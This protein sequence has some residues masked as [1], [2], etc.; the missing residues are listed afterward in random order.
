MKLIQAT[1]ADSDRL[2]EFFARML[3]PGTIDFSIQ[4]QGSF[5]DQYRLQS[6]DF[7]TWM[8]EDGDGR[9]C[10]LASLVFRTGFIRGEKQT[11]CHATDLRIARSRQAVMQWAQHFLPVLERACTDRNCRQVF[12]VVEQSDSQAYNALIRPTSHARRKLPR[13]FL[14]HRFHV[15]TLHGRVPLAP[16]PLTSIRLKPLEMSDVEPLCAYLR[17]QA[18]ARALA[19][20]YEPNDFLEDFK[21]WPGYRWEDFRIARDNK[22]NIVGCAG[23]WNGSQVQNFVPQ[24]YKGFAHTLHQSLN[25]ISWVGLARPTAQPERPMPM[26]FLTHLNCDNAEVFYRLADEAFS[27]LGP[28]EF[29]AYGHFKGHWKTLP[30]RAFIAAAMR[31]GLYT[32]LPPQGEAPAWLTPNPEGLPPEFEAAWI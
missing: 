25:L 30:P 20:V 32:I 14:A 17:E 29:L 18:K 28:K 15:V 19:N 11:W 26:R 16:K 2:K 5:F 22:G 12:S 7:E 4:R 8:L 23:L 31:F 3:L 13:Y 24:T 27:R 21:R 6:D 10:G 1:E 9:L